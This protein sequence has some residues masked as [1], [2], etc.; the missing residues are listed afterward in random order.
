MAIVHFPLLVVLGG[1]HGHGPL[2]AETVE[3]ENGVERRML[4]AIVRKIGGYLVCEILGFPQHFAQRIELFGVK[5]AGE[6]GS[7]VF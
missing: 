5:Q 2:A 6:Q 7:G 3:I 4:Q 1:E